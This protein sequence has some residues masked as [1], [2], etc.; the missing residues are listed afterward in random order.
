MGTVPPVYSVFTHCDLIHRAAELILVDYKGSVRSYYV[1]PTEGYQESHAF[2]FCK[3]YPS[4]ITTA[5][6]HG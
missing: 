5:I 3:A 6:G 4:G 2:S 1:S